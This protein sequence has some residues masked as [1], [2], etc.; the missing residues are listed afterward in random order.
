ML[1]R[2]N[3]VNPPA[4]P[5][6]V[7][8]LLEAFG[9]DGSD[10]ETATLG[11]SPAMQEILRTVKRLA[12]TSMTVLIRGESG[13]GKE[14]VARLIHRFSTRSDKPFVAINCAALSETVL[15]S[16]LFGHE[17][18]AFTGAST[19]H[20]GRFERADSGTLFL[21]EIGDTTPAFQMRLL[22][23]LQEG[24]FERVGGRETIKT[25]VR[26]I[27]A[28]NRDLEGAITQGRFRLDLYYRLNVV[29][30]VIPPLRERTDDIPFLVNRILKRR[31]P[32]IG[33]RIDGLSP[34]ALALLSACKWPGNVRELENCVMRAAVRSESGTVEAA[35]FCCMRGR[36]AS[37]ELWSRIAHQTP[38]GKPTGF[39]AGPATKTDRQARNAPK[40]PA[41]MAL[42]RDVLLETLKREGWVQARAAR[43]LGVTPRQIGYALRRLNIVVKPY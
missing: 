13:S 35:D 14:I 39:P 28:T 27:A 23:V 36:C 34:T 8:D 25:D 6:T 21:D 15:E 12:G 37:Q 22:R 5:F 24:E 2:L 11:R 10:D 40:Q 7:T 26:V 1:E 3:I 43:V 9:V 29:E 20:K 42:P 19:V 16:E 31:E 18:G 30:I 33:T 32:E 17:K 41:A 38:A 4:E